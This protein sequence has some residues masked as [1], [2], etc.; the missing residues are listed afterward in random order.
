MAAR[1]ELL[2]LAGIIVIVFLMVRVVFPDCTVREDSMDDSLFLLVT[3][4]L[5]T[6]FVTIMA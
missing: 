4:F 6:L 3:V 2:R 1:L 5:I